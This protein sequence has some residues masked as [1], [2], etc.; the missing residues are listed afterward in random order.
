MI[1]FNVEDTEG[2][3][4]LFKRLLQIGE[5]GGSGERLWIVSVCVETDE[6]QTLVGKGGGDDFAERRKG[7][8]PV[9]VSVL[10]CS[11]LDS[12]AAVAATAGGRLR[13][14]PLNIGHSEEKCLPTRQR[15]QR[16][17]LIR[18]SRSCGVSLVNGAAPGVDPVA[19]TVAIAVEEVFAVEVFRMAE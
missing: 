14:D 11:E 5:G 12:A 17:S 6:R 7:R 18:R 3:V 9:E 16:P 1:V 8:L 10:T 15:K 2:R 13:G 19:E 4:V